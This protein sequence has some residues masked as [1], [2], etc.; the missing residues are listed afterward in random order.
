MFNEIVGWV[1]GRE[2]YYDG[3][4]ESVDL[5]FH[6]VATCPDTSD[7]WLPVVLQDR[8]VNVDRQGPP[9]G[10]ISVEDGGCID[11]LAVVNLPGKRGQPFITRATWW[12]A[13]KAWS[14]S[15]GICEVSHW[16]SLP[17]MPLDL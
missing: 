7:N 9:T 4:L 11:V 16:Q 12:I 2:S 6:E 8:W 10:P 1:I 5:E 3:F 13:R 14:C 17:D 15:G